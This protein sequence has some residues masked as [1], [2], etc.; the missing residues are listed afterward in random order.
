MCF[1]SVGARAG[2]GESMVRYFPPI[3]ALLGC[4]L[5]SLSQQC[6]EPWGRYSAVGEWS[7]D[8]THF[9]SFSGDTSSSSDGFGGVVRTNFKYTFST[10]CWSRMPQSPIPVGYRATAVRVLA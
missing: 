6:S 10:G 8:G 4:K 1:V 3:F 7:A 9:Y 2:A 5:G